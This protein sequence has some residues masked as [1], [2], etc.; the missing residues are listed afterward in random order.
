MLRKH[1][2]K[3]KGLVPFNRQFLLRIYLYLCKSFINTV[4]SEIQLI[5]EGS[6]NVILNQFNK[7][8]HVDFKSFLQLI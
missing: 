8:S 7:I 2:Q 5:N 6:T 4:L 1:A 3:R